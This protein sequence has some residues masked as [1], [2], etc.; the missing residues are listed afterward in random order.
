M[1]T[2]VFELIPNRCSQVSEAKLETNNSTVAVR[3]IYCT[4]P[5]SRKPMEARGADTWIPSTRCRDPFDLPQGEALRGCA[6]IE[7]DSSIKK[8]HKKNI[9]C[10]I[11]F[12]CLFVIMKYASHQSLPRYL[13]EIGSSG[14]GGGGP[15]PGGVG[16]WR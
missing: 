1:F 6:F 7:Q 16:A 2:I 8:W 12:F 3:Q 15:S 9:E 11:Y 13:Q 4:W 5:F 14:G 10:A